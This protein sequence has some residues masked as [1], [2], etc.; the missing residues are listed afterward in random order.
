MRKLLAVCGLATL[1]LL[2]SNVAL[3]SQQ[4]VTQ[5]QLNAFQAIAETYYTPGVDQNFLLND[6][7]QHE[8][9]WAFSDPNLIQAGMIAPDFTLMSFFNEPYTLS[10]YLGQKFVVLITGSWY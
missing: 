10:Q 6:P 5:D 3:L 1:V 4:Q 7:L 9:Q 2:L 8:N